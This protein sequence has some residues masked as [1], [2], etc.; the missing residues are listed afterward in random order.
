M[1]EV[2]VHICNEKGLHARAASCFASEAAKYDSHITVSANN[3]SAEATS[4][5]GLM[6]LTAAKGCEVTI[7]AEGLQ[8]QEALEALG[9]L[10]CA[11][12]H[13]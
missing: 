6:M 1:P 7:I 4:I 3:M 13:E 10:I 5:M 11:G 12:F 9:N 2:K 8:A